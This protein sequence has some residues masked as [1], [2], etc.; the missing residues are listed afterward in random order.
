MVTAECALAT[1]EIVNNNCKLVTVTNIAVQCFLCSP[2]LI[3]SYSLVY[4]YETF[5]IGGNLNIAMLI[6]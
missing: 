3:I 1:L 2:D 5:E 4:E 6:L